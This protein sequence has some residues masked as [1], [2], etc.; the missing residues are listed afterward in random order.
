MH[1]Q[2]LRGAWS[3]S[4]CRAGLWALKTLVN[5]PQGDRREMLVA[6]HGFSAGA[7]A[8]PRRNGPATVAAETKMAPRGLTIKLERMRAT[9]GA[10]RAIDM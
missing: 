10:K 6:A 2:M 9:N 8:D 3:H 7:L 1:S 5:A 4:C